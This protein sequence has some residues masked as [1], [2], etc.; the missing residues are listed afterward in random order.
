MDLLKQKNQ[1]S[2]NIFL[3]F[4]QKKYY[5]FLFYYYLRLF[6]FILFYL[7]IWIR[8]GGAY[9]RKETHS[10]ASNFIYPQSET[11]TKSIYLS[12]SQSQISLYISL[13]ICVVCMCRSWNRWR[14]H[15]GSEL[16]LGFIR[17]FLLSSMAT[18]FPIS[19]TAAQVSSLFSLSILKVETYHCFSVVF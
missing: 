17:V 19:L 12:L 2:K 15:F 3:F 18:P 13:Y 4:L 14:S 6:I 5:L 9:W 16:A 7:Y 10:T 8:L 1:S 11:K